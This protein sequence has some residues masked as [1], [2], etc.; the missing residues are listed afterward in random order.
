MEWIP[1]SLPLLVN[2]GAS[3]VDQQ[4]RRVDVAVRAGDEQRRSADSLCK[5]DVRAVFDAPAHHGGVLAG[6][7]KRRRSYLLHPVHVGAAVEE[8][9]RHVIVA[10]LAREGECRA[11]VHISPVHDG[12]APLEE[13]PHQVDM[14]AL[15]RDAQGRIVVRVCQIN[16]GATVEEQNCRSGVTLLARCV[17][18]RAPV[19]R[20][21]VHVGAAVQE[22]CRRSDP[23]SHD[24]YRHVCPPCFHHW[25]STSRSRHSGRAQFT[26][27]PR[28]SKRVATSTCVPPGTPRRAASR[29]RY[30]CRQR[31]SRFRETSANRR[32]A[33]P[34]TRR[35]CRTPF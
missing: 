28:S 21:Q 25:T 33:P 26:S 27:A 35:G 17:Q 16:L 22:Q 34:R 24:T 31:R 4:K 9:R 12:A 2:V 1:A 32:R 10:V 18:R 7:K 6:E 30:P 23:C 19:L 5:V 8:E 20:C 3:S 14:T 13:Q 15:A 11:A 29:L